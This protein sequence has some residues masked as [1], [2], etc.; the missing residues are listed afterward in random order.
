MNQ[1][2]QEKRMRQLFHE[3]R[4]QDEKQAPSF[5]S[6]LDAALA[7]QGAVKSGWQSWRLATGVA[8][9][10]ILIGAI[11]FF[12]K[13]FSTPLTM[14][15]W[16]QVP[17]V[18]PVPLREPELP[19]D[20]RPAPILPAPYAGAPKRPKSRSSQTGSPRKEPLLSAQHRPMPTENLQPVMLISN[21]QS[22]T[23]GLLKT[24]GAELLKSIP[25]VGEP[26]VDMKNL[27]PNEKN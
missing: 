8:L 24:P 12:S 11:F 22:P 9:F 3:L 25:Q 16:A 27:F 7:N 5:A 2:S 1:N 21:W 6:A 19:K 18:A 14:E 4:E 23:A 15:P 26:L 13:L 17:L 20:A 10:I